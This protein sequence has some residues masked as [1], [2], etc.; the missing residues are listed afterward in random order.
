MTDQVRAISVGLCM[1]T[2]MI[3]SGE[4]AK[5]I[6]ALKI[7]KCLTDRHLMMGDDEQVEA[8]RDLERKA[9]DIVLKYEDNEFLKEYKIDVDLTCKTTVTVTA[10]CDEEAIRLAEDEATEHT[11]SS[12]FEVEDYEII[13][14]KRLEE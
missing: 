9:E 4:A 10:R 1:D 13:S 2:S 8:V 6:R 11:F 7:P 14:R 5:E 3:E 12:D